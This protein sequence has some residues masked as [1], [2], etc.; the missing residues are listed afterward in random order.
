MFNRF[1][2]SLRDFGLVLILY[3]ATVIA[4]AFRSP[5]L[6]DT[7]LPNWIM[8]V[9]LVLLNLTIWINIIVVSVREGDPVDF[10]PMFLPV[11]IIIVLA[12]PFVA[13]AVIMLVITYTGYFRAPIAAV[14]LG[15]YVLHTCPGANPLFLFLKEDE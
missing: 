6:P 2:G 5:E 3:F 12:A 10:G 15:W 8:F 4:V 7:S 13:G 1:Y 11:A 9:G 14:L